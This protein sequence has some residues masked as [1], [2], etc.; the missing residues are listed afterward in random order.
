MFSRNKL[1]YL[2][3]INMSCKKF[4]ECY[5]IVEQD[6]ICGHL[7]FNTLKRSEY[8]IYPHFLTLKN[9][10]FRFLIHFCV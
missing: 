10:V 9:C 2:L 6:T 1:S 5:R 7:N 4:K 3:K 8:F